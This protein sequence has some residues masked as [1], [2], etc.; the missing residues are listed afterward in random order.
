[1]QQQIQELSRA[2]RE[3]MSESNKIVQQGS[4]VQ[5]KES[6]ELILQINRDVNEQMRSI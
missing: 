6:K 2:M 5:F 4:Q 3:Q 1:M